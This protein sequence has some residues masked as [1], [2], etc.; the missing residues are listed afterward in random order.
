[1]T[2]DVAL[3]LRRG[4]FIDDESKPKFVGGISSLQDSRVYTFPSPFDTMSLLE[5]GVSGE[6]DTVIV[7]QYLGGI[8]P[9]IREG[10][11]I[12][13]LVNFY[14]KKGVNPQLLDSLETQIEKARTYFNPPK[15]SQSPQTKQS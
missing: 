6:E 7:G 9:E 3:P 15:T 8:K 1:M 5:G 4:F 13:Q 2:L 14:R 12:D 10:Q 11:P